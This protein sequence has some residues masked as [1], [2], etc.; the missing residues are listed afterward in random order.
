MS[1][2]RPSAEYYRSVAAEIDALAEQ[3]R[4]P[5]VQRELRVLAER[6]RRMAE[7]RERGAGG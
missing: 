3:S 5:E 6:F 2:P 4:V 7:R 1:D